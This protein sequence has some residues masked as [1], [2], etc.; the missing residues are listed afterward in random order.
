MTTIRGQGAVIISIDSHP[1]YAVGF[2]YENDPIFT[3]IEPKFFFLE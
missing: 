2:D 3:D 1:L